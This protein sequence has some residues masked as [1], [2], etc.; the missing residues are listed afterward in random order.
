MT[1]HPRFQPFNFKQWVQDNQRFLQP[2]VN[3][4]LLHE[5]S[6]MIVMVVGG[7]NRNNFV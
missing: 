6:G 2:P 4:R 1:H 7:P 5:G 3:N